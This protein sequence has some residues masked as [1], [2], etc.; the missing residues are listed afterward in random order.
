MFVV[1]LFSD[2]VMVDVSVWNNLKDLE[3]TS[4]LGYQWNQSTT[5]KAL[6]TAHL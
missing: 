1:I 4:A 6:L 5:S 3:N 2:S